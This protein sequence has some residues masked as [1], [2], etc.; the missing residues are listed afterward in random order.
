MSDFAKKRGVFLRINEFTIKQQLLFLS[1]VLVLIPTAI[2]GVISYESA[3]SEIITEVHA[4]LEVQAGLI[5]RNVESLYEAAQKKKEAD[6][7]VARAEFYSQGK[8]YLSKDETVTLAVTNQITKE[9]KQITI[10]HMMI[11]DEKILYNYNA[12]DKI[13]S[14]VGG[15]STIFQIIPGGMVRIS[16]NVQNLDKT[17]AVLTY[18]P[19]DS[20]V[21]KSVMKGE[22]YS[23]RAFVVTGWY[24]AA[25]EPIK[26]AQG[27][28][29]GALFVGVEEK[30]YQE[31]IL[32]KL[33]EI[34][35]GQTGYI[36]ILD[37]KGNYVLSSG[38]KRDG[39]NIWN[40]TD[41]NGDYFI[42]DIV[43]TG[44]KLKTEETALKTY[45]WQNIGESQARLKAAGYTYFPEWNW[46]VAA[47]A[48]EDEFYA[49]IQHIRTITLIVASIAVILSALAA[50]IVADKI[51]RSFS[52]LI[53]KMNLV[54]EGDLKVKLESKQ[55]KNEIT[56]IESAFA[57]M[58]ANIKNL[59]DGII[60]S[61]SMAASAAEQFSASAEEVNATSMQVSNT[62]QELAK[63]SQTLSKQSA[64]TES[65]VNQMIESL[66]SISQSAQSS[67]KNAEDATIA[68]KKGAGAAKIASETMGSL[69]NKVAESAQVVRELGD[70]TKEIN[71]IVEVINS[72]SEETNLLALN[73]AIEAAR[74]GDAGRGF[75]V[76]ADEVRKLAEQSQSSTARIEE[77]IT[78]IIASTGRAVKTM[79]EGEDEMQKG[80]QVV[81]EALGSL[82]TISEKTL[83]LS[84]QVQTISTAAQSQIEG[85]KKVLSSV[86]EVSAIAEESAAATEEVS[87]SMEETTSSIHQVSDAAQRLA[88][89]TDELR[90]LISKFKV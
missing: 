42:R 65:R 38:R 71:K 78:R 34:K 70:Q 15:S 7:N 83:A 33:A 81:V 86:H 90:Q 52:S 87:A 75:A 82:E 55:G 54:S 8:P 6:L 85:S 21:Y 29:I 79:E 72:I 59:I 20:P 37:D 31:S 74:A 62:I 19:D 16:T 73:A 76:V 45:P 53:S 11:N 30:Y 57:G 89:T 66:S 43:N 9:K 68:A 51:S 24:M 27:E 46:I 50:Y 26:D 4:N 1:I 61:S 64:D 12:V 60:K 22:T 2:L 80:N 17:R 14:I 49:G 25:Y 77:M 18:I 32:Q 40:A 13:K 67:S 36:Y 56:Q 69:K 3:K 88:K 5:L 10:P 48:Y 35:I 58:V 84:A 44:L 39:E 47:S 23:G 28:I 41:A 63:G